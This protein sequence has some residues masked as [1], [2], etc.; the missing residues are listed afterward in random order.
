[1]SNEKFNKDWIIGLQ[2]LSVLPGEI[3]PDM[4]AA[5]GKLEARLNTKKKNRKPLLYWLAAASVLTCILVA[6][7]P[8]KNGKEI[9]AHHFAKENK[10]V[11]K[12]EI[13]RSFS[14]ENS[15][16]IV[17]APLNKIN[18]HGHVLNKIPVIKSIPIAVVQVPLVIDI[19]ENKD[20]L[21]ASTNIPQNIKSK[22]IVFSALKKKMPVI[23]INDIEKPVDPVE[24][25]AGNNDRPAFRIKLFSRN[26]ST[27]SPIDNNDNSSGF[28]IKLPPQN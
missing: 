1:M 13:I 28:N 12:K 11:D 24:A 9:V 27:G 10:P 26:I 16:D 5:W 6:I 17:I 23:H 2:E 18:K 19:Q 22:P 4:N 20:N 8:G 21:P 7:I 14:P 25:V 3:K 15:K